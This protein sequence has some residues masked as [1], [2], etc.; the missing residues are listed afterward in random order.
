MWGEVLGSPVI[1]YLPSMDKALSLIPTPDRHEAWCYTH[2]I[3]GLGRWRQ[4]SQEMR[5]I[6][7]SLMYLKLA[8]A[9]RDPI[10]SKER[11][12]RRRRKG[13]NERINQSI[14]LCNCEARRPQPAQHE[15]VLLGQAQRA[16]CVTL[17]RHCNLVT[18]IQTA[19]FGRHGI[20]DV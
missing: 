19:G 14:K 8:L 20:P 11:E 17:P 6:L 4:E 16:R 5:A 13:R 3:L 15:I 10:T 9:A 2:V 7:S 12:R 1:K 18:V